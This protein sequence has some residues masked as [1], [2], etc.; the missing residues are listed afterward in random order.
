MRARSARRLSVLP[1][2]TQL[3]SVERSSGVKVRV[4]G[5]L[6]MPHH[7]IER[8]SL[9]LSTRPH[10]A[11]EQGCHLVDGRRYP[12]RALGADTAAL[13]RLL[14]STFCASN[15]PRNRFSAASRA[16]FP[17]A[18]ASDHGHTYS[19]STRHCP[20][21]FCPHLFCRSDRWPRCTRE[22]MRYVKNCRL[23][24]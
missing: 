14:P 2:R 13:V 23:R 18:P 8:V 3:S 16:C 1:A 19:T 15:E 7:D 21:W 12:H 22:R 5:Y 10:G 6:L 11:G 24:H 20:D 9:Q 17:C 4:V